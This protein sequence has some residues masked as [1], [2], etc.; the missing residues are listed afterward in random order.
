MRPKVTELLHLD[1]VKEAVG[2]TTHVKSIIALGLTAEE[3]NEICEFLE[4]TENVQVARVIAGIMEHEPRSEYLE[5]LCRAI[6]RPETEI[7]SRAMATLIRARYPKALDILFSN[8]NAQ[9][10]IGDNIGWELMGRGDELTDE[11]KAK[12]LEL[13]C[14][15]FGEETPHLDAFTNPWFR[16]LAEIGGTNDRAAE[17]LLRILGELGRRN[18]QARYL[19]L[20]AMAG[21][22]HP[23][24]EP[25]LKKARR[26]S[27]EDIKELGVKGLAKLEGQ[28]PTEG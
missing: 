25:V 4:T 26:S 11:M 15:R 5:S 9:R 28:Q 3:R 22:P 1:W 21:A 14:R 7:A 23:S 19:V 13:F 10:A 16:M 18:A 2:Y 17:I 24:Y 8:E 27:S 12:F 20:G 6:S